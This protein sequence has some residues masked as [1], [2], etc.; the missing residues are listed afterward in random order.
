VWAGAGF[1]GTV[2]IVHP[3]NGNYIITGQDPVA[4]Q[5]YACTSNLTVYG[6]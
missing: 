5:A 3:P 1:T 4:G 2:T 6:N